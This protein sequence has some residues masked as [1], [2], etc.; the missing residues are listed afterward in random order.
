MLAS[1]AR[2]LLDTA[3]E[4][5]ALSAR[6]YNRV[7]KAARTLADLSHEDDVAATHVAEALRYRAQVTK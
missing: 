4:S 7:A 1:D 6:A 5:L 2:E 3:A